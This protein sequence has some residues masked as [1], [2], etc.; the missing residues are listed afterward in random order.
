MDGYLWCCSFATP[1]RKNSLLIFSDI[2]ALLPFKKFC[3]GAIL[4]L[5]SFLRFLF[6]FSFLFYPY[7]QKPAHF[8]LSPEAHISATQVLNRV[9]LCS[10]TSECRHIAS[11][12]L[13]QD[14]FH[15]YLFWSFLGP[16]R[17]PSKENLFLIQTQL[18]T[19]CWEVIVKPL[20]KPHDTSLVLSHSL[21]WL[22]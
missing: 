4:A 17:L 11:S 7:F 1:E 12:V 15:C 20:N 6:F 2:T 22:I 16:K 9:C 10:H 18:K 21:S 5:G 8:H 14:P 19:T 3:N 13:P